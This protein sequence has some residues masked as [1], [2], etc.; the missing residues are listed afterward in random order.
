M[1]RKLLTIKYNGTN[2]H[3]WQVQKNGISVQKTVCDALEKLYSCKVNATGCSRTDSGVHAI[4]Y[5]LHFDDIKQFDNNTV[6]S[7]LN[8]Y[9]PKDI[10]ALKCKD[11]KS[12]FHARYS[13]KDKTYIYKMYIG[14]RDPFSEGFAYHY[15]GKP[16]IDKMNKFAETL[17]GTHDFAA[18][19]SSGSSVQSTVRTL[20]KA[21]VKQIGNTITFTFCA[22]GFLYNM[23]RILVGTLLYVSDGKIDASCALDIINSKDRKKAGKTVPACGL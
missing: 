5:C 8:S 13:V 21:S 11:V 18:F 4:E 19:C 15:K 20:K 17:L 10:V 7:A 3:G 16:D 1:S 6:V 23:V 14:Q 12:D 22:D 2:Y 9:L